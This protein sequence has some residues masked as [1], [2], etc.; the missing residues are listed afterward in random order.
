[1]E[2][3]FI[4]LIQQLNSS[5]FVLICILVLCFW[6]A[7]KV[8][9]IKTYFTET[10]DKNDK[11]DGKIDSI[12]DVLSKVQATADLLYQS[13]L[14]TVQRQ[15]PISL[16]PLGEEIV[17]MVSVDAKLNEHWDAIRNQIGQGNPQNPYDI[18]T[19]SLSIARDCFDRIF[20]QTEQNEIK[21]FA[22]SRGLN[23][24]EVYPVI[25][26]KI[27][28]KILQERGLTVDAVDQHAPATNKP[29]S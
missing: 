12:K 23:L 21:N 26:V 13:H 15:S 3:V 28:D 17:R 6:G 29:L 25:G 16:T 27:R 18:Q 11:I 10:K 5:V 1:M 7:Y 9:G 20:T 22:Y 4:S 24:L 8:G 14:L 2:S 19:V